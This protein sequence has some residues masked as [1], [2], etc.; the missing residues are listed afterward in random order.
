MLCLV[1]ND[2]INKTSNQTMQPVYATCV[3]TAIYVLMS[4]NYQLEEIAK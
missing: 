1:N 3:D 2:I 4:V